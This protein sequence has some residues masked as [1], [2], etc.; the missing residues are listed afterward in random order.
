MKNK[1]CD[2]FG[3][4]WQEQISNPVGPSRNGRNKLRTYAT[5]KKVLDTDVYVTE[6]LNKKHR[7]ALAKF[8]MGV[9]PIRLETGCYEGLPVEERICPLCGVETENEQ[10]VLLNCVYYN[11]IRNE[12]FDTIHANATKP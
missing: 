3:Q 5:F 4:Q 10:H 1:I 9:A 7:S 6:V 12:L 8:R 11:H 2:F